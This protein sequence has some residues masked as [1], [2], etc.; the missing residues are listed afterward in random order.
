MSKRISTKI[1]ATVNGKRRPEYIAWAGMLERCGVYKGRNAYLEK[2]IE[3]YKEWTNENGF[4]NFYNYIGPKPNGKYVLDRINNDGNY[5]PGNVR[6]ATLS[7]S[8]KNKSNSRIVTVHGVTKNLLDWSNDVGISYA[9]ITERIKRGWSI[10]KAIF[11]RLGQEAKE[12][13]DIDTWYLKMCDII[14][15]RGTCIRRKVGCVLVD[16]HGHVLSTGYNGVPAGV[17]HCIEHPCKGAI[18]KS[19]EGLTECIA[20]HAEESALIKCKDIHSIYTCYCS[21]S[22]CELC[23]RRLLNTSCERIVF[24]DMYPHKQSELIWINAR[25]TWIHKS[26]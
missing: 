24:K 15:E 18:Y 22:P 26:I 19:G 5:E 25:R 6:W 12:R 9:A 10:E 14:K 8:N 16:K 3:V 11:T 7:E 23:I 17:L 21:A 2:G 1:S 4:T 13:P 20:S